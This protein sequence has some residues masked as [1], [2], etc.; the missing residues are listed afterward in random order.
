VK[1]SEDESHCPAGEDKA[2]YGDKGLDVQ[3]PGHKGIN[4]QKRENQADNR[5]KDDA[6]QDVCEL[7]FYAVHIG[8]HFIILQES[9]QLLINLYFISPQQNRDL[10]FSCR[11]QTV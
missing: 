10:P 8:L 11:P 5:P 4:G 3:L 9:F 6:G 7:F 2:G 1:Q